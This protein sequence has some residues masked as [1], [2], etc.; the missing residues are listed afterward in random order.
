MKSLVPLLALV[1]AN[2][3]LAQ[4]WDADFDNSNPQYLLIKIKSTHSVS[5]DYADDIME[6]ARLA[7]NAGKG[8]ALQPGVIFRVGS[9]VVLR[10]NNAG[11]FD[12]NMPRFIEGNQATIKALGS[13][14][15]GNQAPGVKSTLL[16][17]LSPHSM[18]GEYDHYANFYLQNLRL[19]SSAGTSGPV[20]DH[21]RK[22]DHAFHVLGAQRIR[23]SNL[24]TTRSVYAGVVVEG[25][26]SNNQGFSTGEYGGVYYSEF[27]DIHSRYDG[28]GFSIFTRDF[29]TL[30]SKVNGN[31]FINCSAHFSGSG[32][33]AGNGNGVTIKYATGNAWIGGSVE[34]TRGHAFEFIGAQNLPISGTYVEKYGY[35][36]ANGNR[37]SSKSAFY[38]NREL[39]GTQATYPQFYNR[40]VHYHGQIR[41]ERDDGA[42]AVI[43]GP[44]V[45]KDNSISAHSLGPIYQTGGVPL[46]TTPLGAQGGS[47]NSGRIRFIRDQFGDFNVPQTASSGGTPGS[48]RW[49]IGYT[50]SNDPSNS[51]TN[52]F[53]D[54]RDKLWF[55]DHAWGAPTHSMAMRLVM[56]HSG[57]DIAGALDVDGPVIADSFTVS[58]SREFKEDIQVVDPAEKSK[59]LATL[60][61]LGLRRYKYKKE[62]SRD[63][64]LQLGFIA[65]EMPVDVVTKDRKAI[66]VNRLLHYSIG[67]MQAQQTQIEQQAEQLRTQQ[68]Q[69]DDLKALVS[70]LS[71]QF[72]D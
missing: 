21:L 49:S 2:P 55:R 8:L 68:S 24:Y 50:H 41:D 18:G 51:G 71:E 16:T 60:K 54:Q 58:S 4:N 7:H 34:K 9:P 14:T 33:T 65:E 22:A 56:D 61:Q 45:S 52:P 10:P 67:A 66:H 26:R 59:M 35:N 6:G 48:V 12:R 72:E 46:R 11:G 57:V 28:E 20:N 13:F 17:I 47:E 40:H 32:T 62:F 5:T 38:F 23:V 15:P 25:T 39:T 70:K 42:G 30:G 43:A 1:C 31:S 37:Y 69:I 53:F 19:D 3:I 36:H 44:D 63:N 64:D 27:R 29:A